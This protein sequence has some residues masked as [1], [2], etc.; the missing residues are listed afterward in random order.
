[1]SKKTVVM[2]PDADGRH[3]SVYLD[4]ELIQEG[5]QTICAVRCAWVLRDFLAKIGAHDVEVKTL[6]C[7]LDMWR[8]LEIDVGDE[9]LED[10][11]T[12]MDEAGKNHGLVPS[13]WG[14]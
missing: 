5:S 13:D 2:I 11:V 10:L 9:R 1:M 8:E 6:D 14:E 12:R 3:G 4:G 7:S